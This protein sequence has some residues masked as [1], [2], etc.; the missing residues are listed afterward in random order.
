MCTNVCLIKDESDVLFRSQSLYRLYRTRCSDYKLQP[1]DNWLKTSQFSK[2]TEKLDF[3]CSSCDLNYRSESRFLSDAVC[4]PDALMIIR[5]FRPYRGNTPQP[6]SNNRTQAFSLQ[7]QHLFS[8]N[9]TPVMCRMQFSSPLLTQQGVFYFEDCPDSQCCSCVWLPAIQ[10]Q[11]FLMSGDMFHNAMQRDSWRAQHVRY[12]EAVGAW[13][14]PV[15]G[16]VS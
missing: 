9:T 7:V 12:A 2:E 13:Y 14:I 1:T 3:L 16:Y 8:R 10:N 15:V 4:C 5:V 6:H 11:C